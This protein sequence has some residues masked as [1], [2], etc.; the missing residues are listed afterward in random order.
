[1]YVFCMPWQVGASGLWDV[2]TTSQL[3][4]LYIYINFI[5]LRISVLFYHYDIPD[6]EDIFHVV[7]RMGTCH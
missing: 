6:K 4:S 7:L 2:R 5:A 3:L 1:M